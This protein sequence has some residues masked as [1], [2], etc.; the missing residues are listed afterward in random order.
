MYVCAYLLLDLLDEVLLQDLLV[1]VHVNEF[2]VLGLHDRLLLDLFFLLGTCYVEIL[3]QLVQLISD[4][5]APVIVLLYLLLHLDERL[6]EGLA[7]GL[8]GQLLILQHL[9]LVHTL[10]DVL[11][12]RNQDRVELVSL[13]KCV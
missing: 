9:E 7:V 4:L 11:P 8:H 2:I 6:L 13:Y 12:R 1:L 3:P 10:I 5:L